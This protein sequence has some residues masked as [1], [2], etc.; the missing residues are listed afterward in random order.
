M[1]RTREPSFQYTLLPDTASPTQS[2]YHVPKPCHAGPIIHKPKSHP[3]KP[4]TKQLLFLHRLYLVIL[5]FLD[6]CKIVVGLT[7]T[8]KIKYCN[9]SQRSSIIL[10]SLAQKKI[11]NAGGSGLWYLCQKLAVESISSLHNIICKSFQL[12]LALWRLLLAKKL[13][14]CDVTVV[15]KSYC[16]DGIFTL[17]G[18]G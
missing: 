5:L 10:M 15:Q 1:P 11:K 2:Y 4:S 8:Q 14:I 13:S 3:A 18:W 17:C 12:V 6:L 9:K 16:G 7:S